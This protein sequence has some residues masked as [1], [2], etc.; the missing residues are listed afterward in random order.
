MSPLRPLAVCLA[1]AALIPVPASAAEVTLPSNARLLG[2]RIS[3]LGSYALPVGVFGDGKVPVQRLEGKI[4]RQSWRL[5]GASQTTLQVLAPLRGQLLAAGYDIVFECRDFDCGGFDFRFGTEVI[6]APDMHVNIRDYRFLSAMRGDDE[7]LGLL[8]SRAGNS[9]YIQVI[10]TAAAGQ[11][12]PIT[13]PKARPDLPVQSPGSDGLAD[14]LQ[15]AG[16]VVL[17]DLVFETGSAQLG[18][19]PFASLQHL[20]GFLK[21]GRAS[22]RERV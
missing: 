1:L 5:D 21:I 4:E 14:E 22:C 6:P 7:S 13:A 18:K 20:A 3:P 19:G 11:N 16:H 12:R 8:V 10:H 2:D 15:A 9:T 17:A